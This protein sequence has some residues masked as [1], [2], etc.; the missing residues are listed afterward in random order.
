MLL[1]ALKDRSNGIRELFVAH[2]PAAKSHKVGKYNLFLEDDD[3]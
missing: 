3:H 2:L 1:V